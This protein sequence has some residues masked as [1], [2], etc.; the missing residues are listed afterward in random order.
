MF[1][2]YFDSVCQKFSRIG[3]KML[4]STDPLDSGIY[5]SMRKPDQVTGEVLLSHYM[6]VRTLIILYQRFF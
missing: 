5:V 2:Y 3:L 4:L 1:I 6:T